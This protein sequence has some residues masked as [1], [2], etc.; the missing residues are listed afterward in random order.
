[1]KQRKRI[2]FLG[3]RVDVWLYSDDEPVEGHREGVFGW[4]DYDIENQEF[5]IGFRGLICE[6]AIVHEC[7]H[8]YFAILSLMDAKEHTMGD[9]IDEIYAYSFQDLYSKVLETVTG[10]KLYKRIWNERKD[11]Q[12]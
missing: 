5:A 6:A 8:L 7:F 4:C 10:M 9:L 11:D 2:E 1:M 12:Q 3:V